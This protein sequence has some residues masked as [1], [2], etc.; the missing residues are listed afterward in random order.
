M[1]MPKLQGDIDYAE[2]FNPRP[3]GERVNECVHAFEAPREP[4]FEKM[5]RFVENP[6]Y[7]LVFGTGRY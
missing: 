5:K 4:D 6:D 1:A 3:K 7:S 2:V